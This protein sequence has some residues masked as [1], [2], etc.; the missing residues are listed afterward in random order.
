LRT[1]LAERVEAQLYWN[2]ATHGMVLA[3]SAHD[4]IVTLRGPAADAQQAELARLIAVN[5]C[6]V[7]R[8][9]S[10]LQIQTQP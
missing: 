6:R 9:N 5:T 2:R 3:V 7:K 10:D 1:G 4:G 8:V